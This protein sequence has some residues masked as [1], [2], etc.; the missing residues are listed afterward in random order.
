MHKEKI[1]DAKQVSMGIQALTAN[2]VGASS[3]KASM[4][5]GG[6]TRPPMG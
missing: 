3:P 6:W 5:R 1:Q 2:Y 4:K